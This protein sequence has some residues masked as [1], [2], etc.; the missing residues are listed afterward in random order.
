MKLKLPHPFSKWLFQLK[1]LLLI[2]R[3]SHTEL[4]TFILGPI[5]CS[6]PLFLFFPFL[7]EVNI[8]NF[9]IYFFFKSLSALTQIIVLNC[10]YCIRVK[11][12][13]QKYKV[14]C[15]AEF[16]RLCMHYLRQ[17]YHLLSSRGILPD[18]VQRMDRACFKEQCSVF[19]LLQHM[20]PCWGFALS[21]QD[22]SSEVVIFLKNSSQY[23]QQQTQGGLQVDYWQKKKL[24]V[25]HISLTYLQ[26]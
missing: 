18:G 10:R 6:W 4:E 17:G 11:R 13:F 7:F 19:L 12:T 3:R 5:L 22:S 25:L 21:H 14:K 23:V 20:G 2:H 1:E 9:M 24:S 8:W 16:S 15:S 26:G